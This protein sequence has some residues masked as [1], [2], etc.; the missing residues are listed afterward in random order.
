MG[1]QICAHWEV[2][3]NNT[4]TAQMVMKKKLCEEDFGVIDLH[5]T[6]FN[7]EVGAEWGPRNKETNKNKIKKEGLSGD[8]GQENGLSISH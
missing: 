3:A 8:E 2:K 1:I 4:H 6:Q 5:G 7:M